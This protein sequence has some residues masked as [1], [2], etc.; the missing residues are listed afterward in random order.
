MAL[1]VLLAP[2][3]YCSMS[4]GPRP[5][6]AGTGGAGATQLPP[7]ASCQKLSKAASTAG[8]AL[9]AAPTQAL[10][11]CPS[12]SPLSW[13][14]NVTMHYIVFSIWILWNWNL[15]QVFF[16]ECEVGLCS[17]LW[18]WGGRICAAGQGIP[19]GI[20]FKIFQTTTFKIFQIFKIFQT[21]VNIGGR[22][23]FWFW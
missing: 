12:P 7:P 2:L 8:K 9:P 6:A 17:A 15:Y 20:N 5:R 1:I 13:Y 3:A 11:S 14:L 19:T 22:I 16:Y 10:A 21:T 4:G 23:S 18:N